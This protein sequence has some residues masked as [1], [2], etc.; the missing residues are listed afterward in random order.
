MKRTLTLLAAPC[1]FLH[2]CAYVTAVP[3]HDNASIKGI[4]VY[5]PKAFAVVNGNSVSTLVVP[6]CSREYAIRFGS[7][8]AKNDTTLEMANGMLTKVDNKQDTTALPIKLVDAVTQAAVAGKS[9]GSA[10]SAKVDGGTE[11]M[12]GVYELSCSDGRLIATSVIS[13]A[14]LRPVKT[15]PSSPSPRETA[16]VDDQDPALDRGTAIPGK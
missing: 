7:F 15:A 5:S 4:R 12:F 9:L 3:T 2:G 8:L 11:N 13:E 6:D 1:L 10:F 16:D 14:N